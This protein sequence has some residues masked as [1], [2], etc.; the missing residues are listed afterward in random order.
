[1]RQSLFDTL[2]S[3]SI[4]SITDNTLNV[5]RY[6]VYR[7]IADDAI[8]GTRIENADATIDSSES[9]HRIAYISNKSYGVR[10]VPVTG[11][12]DVETKIEIDQPTQVLWDDEMVNNNNDCSRFTMQIVKKS[13]D[14]PDIYVSF[15]FRWMEK[16][17]SLE[18]HLYADYMDQGF[19]QVEMEDYDEVGDDGFGMAE[20]YNGE[21]LW[22]SKEDYEQ[23]SDKAQIATCV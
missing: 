18:I 15:P 13:T 21:G 7:F 5:T 20:L 16:I 23:L 10:F 14:P 1:M 19:D 9:E 22:I 11:A 6:F 17:K 8:Y 3:G 2:G 4:I 12:H